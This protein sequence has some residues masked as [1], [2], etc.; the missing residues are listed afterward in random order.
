MPLDSHWLAAR[1]DDALARHRV[2][3]AQV[4]LRTATERL[5]VSAGVLAVGSDAPVVDESRFHAGSLAKA[6]T[7]QWVREAALKGQVDLD[8]PCSKQSS[9]D[10]GD[11]P[12]DLL[13]QTSGRPNELPEA[14]EGL[15]DFAAR[16]GAMPRLHAPGRFSYC[17]SGWSVLDLLL[18]QCTGSGFAAH[19]VGGDGG[20]VGGT[21]GMPAAAAL[22]H[23]PGEAGEPVDVPSTYVE[24]AAAA[25]ACWWR[26]PTSSST[27]A[28]ATST[29]RSTVGTPG[30]WNSCGHRR[31]GFRDRR[32]STPGDRAGRRGGAVSTRPSAG[33]ASRKGT[34]AICGRSRDTTPRSSC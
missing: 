11:T 16:I 34:G 4:G 29:P 31:R 27:S 26:T 7:G 25:G 24:S 9:V 8:A 12:Y 2:P 28:S 3:G 20:G 33:A 1:L 6:L 30:W 19:L 10:W 13:T 23:A 5:V 14:G 32:S 17:N 15:E 18:H 22:G 21:F